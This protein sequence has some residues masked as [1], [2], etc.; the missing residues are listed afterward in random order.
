MII[1]DALRRLIGGQTVDLTID[2]TP[3]TRE[4]KFGYGDQ[5]ELSK[6]I[7]DKKTSKYPLVW[8][9]INPYFDQ[10]DKYSVKSRLIILQGTE[11]Y[12]FNTKRFVKSYTEVIEPVWQK[13]KK[14]L[15]H[16]TYIT[17]KGNK[18]NKYFIKD[19]PN[20]GV[21]AKGFTRTGQTDFISKG[22]KGEQSI[23]IDV[24][25]A[26]LIDLEFNISTNCI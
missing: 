14:L 1:G 2:G 11:V 15:E 12:W 22:K 20:Y 26:R 23:T 4:I 5:R 25:D 21:E 7:D 17:L 8:Y 9:V 16:S 13:V 19:E 6:W 18:P 10:N 24:V 3:I